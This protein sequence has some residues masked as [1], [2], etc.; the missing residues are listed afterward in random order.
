MVYDDIFGSGRD[1]RFLEAKTIPVTDRKEFGE[2]YREISRSPVS[3]VPF[4]DNFA[5]ICNSLGIQPPLNESEASIRFSEMFVI[6]ADSLNDISEK[7]KPI[8]LYNLWVQ[9]KLLII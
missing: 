1:R 9:N 3:I 2:V 4:Y 5:P 6:L 7:L 8:D